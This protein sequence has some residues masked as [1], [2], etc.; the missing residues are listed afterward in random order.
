MVQLISFYGHVPTNHSVHIFGSLTARI[1]RNTLGGAPAGRQL[2]PGGGGSDA[3]VCAVA[4]PAGGYWHS[5]RPTASGTALAMARPPY[6]P[7]RRCHCSQ[8]VRA[9]ITT[10]AAV[11]AVVSRADQDPPRPAVGPAHVRVRQRA[12]ARVDGEHGGRSHG[13]GLDGQD[14]HRTRSNPAS[15]MAGRST[16]LSDRL[17]YTWPTSAP[18][19]DPRSTRSK[20]SLSTRSFVPT[21]AAA[22]AASAMRATEPKGSP[23]RDPYGRSV[24]L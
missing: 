11:D 21:T 15:Q 4:A 14:R 17:G 6:R 10:A 12:Q 7:P 22:S 13:I 19:R 8:P 3:E 20:P 18:R 1:S 24:A 2:V 16:A 23:A 9:S 5:Q